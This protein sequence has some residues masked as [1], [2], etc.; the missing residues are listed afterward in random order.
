MS[1]FSPNNN[2]IYCY[3]YK[4]KLYG[5]NTRAAHT[6]IWQYSFLFVTEYWDMKSQQ[7]SKLKYCRNINVRMDE[8]L[9]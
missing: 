1:C 9:N 8:W 3:N 7:E 6:H 4:Y 5:P 2:T